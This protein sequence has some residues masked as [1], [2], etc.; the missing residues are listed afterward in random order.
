MAVGRRGRGAE[1]LPGTECWLITEGLGVP[2]GQ[3]ALTGKGP[4]GLPSSHALHQ[5]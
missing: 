5:A 4:L 1:L 3:W 2:G